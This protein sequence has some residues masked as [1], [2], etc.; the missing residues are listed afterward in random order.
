MLIWLAV[1]AVA[2]AASLGVDSLYFDV[3]DFY[4][5]NK[6][7][8]IRE[9]K[10]KINQAI[11]QWLYNKKNWNVS[12]NEKIWAPDSNQKEQSLYDACRSMIFLDEIQDGK[13]SDYTPFLEYLQSWKSKEDFVKEL[14]EEQ[15]TQFQEKW[16]WLE[17]QIKLRMEY[18]D[19]IFKWD[20]IINW[21]KE[22]R[23]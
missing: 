1:W 13:F 19:K 10:S 5:Q 11:L 8:F 12:L 15:K 17:E 7:D 23:W 6:E 21:L 14:N 18:I 4:L 20:E 9:K 2:T 16:N 22:W 3:Q